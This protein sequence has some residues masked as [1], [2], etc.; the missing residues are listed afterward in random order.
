LLGSIDVDVPVAID[1][2]TWEKVVEANTDDADP[3]AVTPAD[4][5]EDALIDLVEPEF[6]FRVAGR[7]RGED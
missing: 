2:D 5:S 7:E 4:V 1:R 6:H 3:E